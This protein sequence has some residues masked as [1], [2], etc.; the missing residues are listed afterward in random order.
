LGSVYRP[1]VGSLPICSFLFFANAELCFCLFV[2]LPPTHSNNVDVVVFSLF[3]NQYNQ[4]TDEPV[5][6]YYVPV[7]TFVQ[8][9]TSQMEQDMSDQGMDDYELP[10]VAQYIYCTPYV[11]SGQY[12]YL[13]IGCADDS[14][15]SLAINIYNDKE[16]TSRSEEGGYDDAS[17]DV[18]EIHVRFVWCCTTSRGIFSSVPN[19]LSLH[20]LTIDHGF[21]SYY[22]ECM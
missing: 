10:D 8:G 21:L 15:L 6:T 2:C 9:Y 12:K 20:S 5:G 17:I 16:C 22:C 7:P 11:I 4:C 19:V 13:Q 3:E 14:V 1:Y 18:T